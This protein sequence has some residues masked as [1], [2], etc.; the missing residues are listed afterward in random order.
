MANT[1][2]LNAHEFFISRYLRI[3]PQLL[4]VT[5]ITSIIS[6]FLV[7]PTRYDNSFS[8]LWMLP[9]GL[10]YY[11]S[12]T[13]GYFGETAK[14]IVNLHFWSLSVEIFY[15]F[16]AALLLYHN[17]LIY[18]LL[19]IISISIF[20]LT[21][22]G[23]KY[24]SVT[25]RGLFFLMGFSLII[26]QRMVLLSLFLLE[27]FYLFTNMPDVEVIRYLVLL[28]ITI[29]FIFS[30]SSVMMLNPIY[31][32]IGH[33]SK[34]SYELFLVHYPI[35]V[36]VCAFTGNT[37]LNQ[38]EVLVILATT[39][40]TG[41]TLYRLRTFIIQHHVS[42]L[43]AG[44][45]IISASQ[46]T[47]GFKFRVDE[48][49]E[50][51][52]SQ[53]YHIVKNDAN[54][55]TL[56]D[57]NKYKGADIFIGDSHAKMYF[58]IYPGNNNDRYYLKVSLTDLIDNY[59]NLNELNNY[60]I[61]YRWT[62]EDVQATKTVVDLLDA[63]KR[64]LTFKVFTEL[65]TTTTNLMECYFKVH[66]FLSRPCP[67]FHGPQLLIQKSK[68]SS[69]ESNQAQLIS[70]AMFPK[71]NIV[72]FLCDTSYCKTMFDDAFVYRDKTHLS[73][74]YGHHIFKETTEW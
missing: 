32:L 4:A 52:S 66:W 47:N 1:T 51:Y 70:E 14:T 2:K 37:Y 3:V 53:T 50:E 12:N 46:L 62:G 19:L 72:D 58:H 57:L 13:L 40:L 35:I 65:P 21:I 45:V 29:F 24:Y 16:F 5:V 22:L 73:E 33:I 49:F 23:D 55:I 63:N 41:L 60:Y 69:L 36:M 10:N 18:V 17:R 48:Q 27:A 54:T 26:R 6:F 67:L 31:P 68:M 25:S 59:D 38:T 20:E 7:T 8:N 15:Y 71:I 61:S 56:A 74:K 42:L 28:I 64:N 34:I 30:S 44:T 11:F 39:Y 43:V 9:L